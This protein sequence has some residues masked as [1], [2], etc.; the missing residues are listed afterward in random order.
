MTNF[1]STSFSPLSSSMMVY[2]R[3]GL[4]LCTIDYGSLKL[5]LGSYLI[6]LKKLIQAN[7][8]NKFDRGFLD[9]YIALFLIRLLPPL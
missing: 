8:G 7:N 6:L 9:L 3:R 2:A 4:F 1:D 5:L